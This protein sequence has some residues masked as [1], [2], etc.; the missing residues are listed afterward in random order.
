[1]D[2]N[3]IAAT[4]AV[5]NHNNN[6]NNIEDDIII[7]RQTVDNKE[8]VF[9]LKKCFIKLGDRCQQPPEDDDSD[10][11][12]ADDTS[13]EEYRYY[14]TTKT[15]GTAGRVLLSDDTE[16][17]DS[18]EN[19]FGRIVEAFKRI[20]PNSD[21]Y[22]NC[23]NSDSD[24]KPTTK[25]KMAPKKG[26]KRG[27]NDR[28]R[29]SDEQPI[30]QTKQRKSRDN[31]T[32]ITKVKS[33]EVVDESVRPS[34][35][36][37]EFAIPLVADENL[38][39]DN[40]YQTNM[41]YF[42]SQ[43]LTQS[44]QSSLIQQNGRFAYWQ[45][46]EPDDRL[47]PRERTHRLDGRSFGHF[48]KPLYDLSD[49]EWPMLLKVL[50]EYK[51]T[52]RSPSK[53]S[54][55]LAHRLL[56][57]YEWT[58]QDCQDLS[59][60][61]LSG[62]RRSQTMFIGSFMNDILLA[63]YSREDILKVLSADDN[64][65]TAWLFV[66]KLISYLINESI[67]NNTETF[68]YSIV[69]FELIVD[70]LDKDFRLFLAEADDYCQDIHRIDRQN[71]R[72]SKP[73]ISRLIWPKKSPNYINSIFKQLI[74]LL[75]KTLIISDNHPLS[76]QLLEQLFRLFELCAECLRI[77]S[78]NVRPFTTF[79]YNKSTP[80]TELFQQ[81]TF[82]SGL[83]HTVMSTL[84][85]LANTCW[86]KL[87]ICAQLMTRFVV[88]LKSKYISEK[89]RQ[90]SLKLIVECFTNAKIRSQ[91]SDRR[92]SAVKTTTTTPSSR[93]LRRRSWTTMADESP[94]K[95]S[96]I[97][98]MVKSKP[99]EIKKKEWSKR[100]KY[101]ENGLH[102]TCKRGNVEKLRQLL[103]ISSDG[104]GL[105]PNEQDFGGYT[106]LCEAAVK[107]HT[108]CIRALIEWQELANRRLDFE[109]GPKGQTALHD[110]IENNHIE[111]ARLLLDSGGMKLLDGVRR[112]L[113]DR[114]PRDLI[115][116]EA[117]RTMIDE[118]VQQKTTSEENKFRPKIEM[119]GTEERQLF[120]RVLAQFIMSYMSVTRLDRFVAHDDNQDKWIDIFYEQFEREATAADMT[121]LIEDLAVVRK[122]PT[123]LISLRELLDNE[124]CE[125]IEDLEFA[126]NFLFIKD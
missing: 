20:V 123:I 112:T 3:S 88:D 56:G 65:A 18:D 113:D 89:S 102:T 83:N 38:L 15:N 82:Q 96:S 32:K 47:R 84:L 11:E 52:F 26:S 72:R 91:R 57:H 40:F 125:P 66:S 93:E 81:L 31:K 79:V 86:V 61:E 43:S 44:S 78:G 100:T 67:K 114:T 10:D 1:M 39:E 120:V 87:Q 103:E 17:Y 92:Q 104:F 117:M 27:S 22:G 75:T 71:D 124:S 19:N 94:K 13:D 108:D 99:K 28:R 59:D 9:V 109:L 97:G 7:Y 23:N 63:C 62:F 95:R 46:I 4:D 105:D 16:S 33:S 77:G 30:V 98:L 126:L 101:G 118:L 35:R 51:Y 8:E 14:P 49:A 60:Q 85:L 110:C 21:C 50:P 111:C 2:T 48:L 54:I 64:T 68:G 116:T 119:N 121:I 45:I 6:N 34:P 76:S 69:Y 5:D 115:R 53:Y 42:M 107:G 36:K 106:P 74:F 12:K 55:L 70:M 29:I 37:Q 58:Q 90:L 80:V 25:K 41:D 24:S 122:L 73:V